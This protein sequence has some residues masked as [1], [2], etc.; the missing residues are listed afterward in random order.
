[1]DAHN[2][3]LLLLKIVIGAAWVDD[4]LA[5]VEQQYLRGLLRQNH[6]ADNLELQSLLNHPVP[7]PET[8][9]WI[10]DYLAG[11]TLDQRSQLSAS[12][13]NLIMAD[14]QISAAEQSLMADFHE[15]LEQI[16][17][18]P[19]AAPGLVKTLGQLFKQVLHKA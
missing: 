2:R 17:V 8:E 6:L 16:Q 1:M 10:V 11:A 13:H 14:S 9:R 15:L 7:L 3:Q 19:D 5:P 12:I 4:T 18:R